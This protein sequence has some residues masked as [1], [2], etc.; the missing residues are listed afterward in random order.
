MEA[1]FKNKCI[2]TVL[3]GYSILLQTYV[4]VYEKLNKKCTQSIN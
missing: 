4:L 3:I 2:G 1:L